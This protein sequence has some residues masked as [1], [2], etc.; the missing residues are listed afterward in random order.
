MDA[1][2]VR[3]I[4]STQATL[5]KLDGQIEEEKSFLARNE[6]SVG[7]AFVTFKT[8]YAAAVASQCLLENNISEWSTRLAPAHTDVVWK[9]V[10]YNSNT[11]AIINV[12]VNLIGAIM[13]TTATLLSNT[14]RVL[15]H[16]SS[17]DECFIP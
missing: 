11:R 7:N 9:N 2:V 1:Q 13:G 12:K 6:N 8:R 14:S 3:D 10:R 15:L 4:Q 17:V 5:L 16:S